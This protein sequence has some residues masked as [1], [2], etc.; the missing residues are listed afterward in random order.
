[1]S[2]NKTEKPTPKKKKDAAKEGQTFK[3]KDLIATCLI[4]VCLEVLIKYL[5]LD[6]FKRIIKN[7]LISSET[8]SAYD[9]TVMCLLTGVGLLIPVLA[10]GIVMTVLPGLLQTGGQLALKALKIKFDS[11]NPVKGIKKIFSIRTVKELL[12]TLLYMTS[13]YMAIKIFW[14]ANKSDIIKLVYLDVNYLFE[15]WGRL[16]HSLLTILLSCIII[17]IAFDCL[18]EFFLWL[19]DLKMDK[20]EVEREQKELNGNPEI[21]GKRREL[22]HELLSVPVKEAINK[23]DAIIV[24]PTHIAIGIYINRDISFIPFISVME[25]DAKAL[26]VKNYAKKVGT[27]VIEDINLARKIYNTHKVHSFLSLECFPKVMDVLLWLD[28]VELSW[29]EEQLVSTSDDKEEAN[30]MPEKPIIHVDKVTE[31]GKGS[32]EL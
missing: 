22:H 4:M 21:K 26:A 31:Y 14:S 32:K 23:S 18:S 17:I 29:L 5:S 20:K 30:D 28:I 3:S 6:E 13:F 2:Q 15:M 19:K 7:I 16:I 12:K 8:I 10:M 11:L 24:N 27:P 1:M 25:K 9:Y